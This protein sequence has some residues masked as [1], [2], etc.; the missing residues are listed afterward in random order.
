M[1]GPHKAFCCAGFLRLDSFAADWQ[2]GLLPSVEAA[3][4]IDDVLES[5]SLQQATGDHAPISA[6]A[7]HGDCHVAIDFRWRNFEIIQWPPG[8]AL[9]VSGFPLGLAAH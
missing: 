8:C 9:D 6:L 2:F 1:G 4:H 7:V 5:G 3:G